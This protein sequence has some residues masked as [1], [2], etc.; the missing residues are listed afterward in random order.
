[1][2][3]D[4]PLLV[5]NQAQIS[6]T[7]NLAVLT[8]AALAPGTYDPV[9]VQCSSLTRALKDTGRRGGSIPALDSHPHFPPPQAH[10]GAGQA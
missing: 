6:L 7:F 8:N 3:A 9:E 2:R 4:R 5:W 1:M 10:S